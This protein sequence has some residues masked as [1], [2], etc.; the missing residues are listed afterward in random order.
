M[1]LNG[2][3]ALYQPWNE[4]EFQADPIVRSMSSYER[5]MYRALLQASFV[6]S[7]RPYL[8]D[9]DHLLWRLAG[10]D[11]KAVWDE[12]K[13]TVRAMFTKFSLDGQKLL[14]QKRVE[15][16]WNRETEYRRKLS[17]RNRDKANKRWHSGSI[18]EQC[19]SNAAGMPDDAT[20]LNRTEL[21]STEQN[22]TE[23]SPLSLEQFAEKVL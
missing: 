4:E 19:P 7:S 15:M 1:S 22:G 20:E 17:E 23:H 14:K 6:C 12:H 8:P 18:P 3:K 21:N 5:W 11:N 9:N 2:N 13:R 10:C 16:D